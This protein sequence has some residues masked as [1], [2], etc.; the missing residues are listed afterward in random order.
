MSRLIRVSARLCQRYGLPETEGRDGEY[1]LVDI[2]GAL[3]AL[4]AQGVAVQSAMATGPGTELKKLL[5]R[6]GFS[7]NPGCACNKRARVMDARGIPWCEEN[8]ETIC[9][10]LAEEAGKRKLPFL[11]SAGRLLIRM[12]IRNAKKGNSQ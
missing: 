8:V 10:W 9:D 5:S 4:A 1:V 12:A 2:K 11:R 6:L 3:A 7:S